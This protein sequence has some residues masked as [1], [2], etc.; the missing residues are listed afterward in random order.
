MF[1]DI[2]SYIFNNTL[3]TYLQTRTF[4]Y[5]EN[6]GFIRRKRIK[7]KFLKK[8]DDLDC[9]DNYLDEFEVEGWCL[10]RES[11]DSNL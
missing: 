6:Y 4:W 10:M 11:R 3:L 7:T 9:N 2:W 1:C 5:C 8:G